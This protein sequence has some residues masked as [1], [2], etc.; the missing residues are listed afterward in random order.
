MTT[1]IPT[2][3][4]G[5]P[6][7]VGPPERPGL[8]VIQDTD[9][10]RVRVRPGQLRRYSR[11]AHDQAEV[12]AAE[13]EQLQWGRLPRAAFGNAAIAAEVAAAYHAR[14]EAGLTELSDLAATVETFGQRVGEAAPAFE[15]QDEQAAGQLAFQLGRLRE[16]VICR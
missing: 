1:S 11:T 10:G 8:L 5:A 15:A 14:I 12:V 2:A 13:R 4:A 9:G 3:G 6:D 16:Q 7:F